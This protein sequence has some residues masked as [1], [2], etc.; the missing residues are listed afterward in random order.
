MKRL[1]NKVI[2]R[3]D[4][5]SYFGDPQVLENLYGSIWDR[6]PIHFAVIPKIYSHQIEAPQ[7]IQHE[8]DF[9][10]IQENT[11]LVSF[12]K[13]KISEGKI[14]ILQHGITHRDYD[15]SY[16]LERLGVD[17]LAEELTE[18]KRILEETFGVLID[19]IVAPHDRFSCDAIRAIE[20]VGYT[21][22]SRGF[23]P[24]PREIQM[25]NASYILAYGRLFF[26]YLFRGRKFRY[27]HIL[28]FGKHKEIF[29]YRIEGK[30]RKSI[31]DIIEN[32][33]ADGVIAMT[34]HHRTFTNVHG[35]VAEYLLDVLEVER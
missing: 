1:K 25:T 15:D 29:N 21:Y 11:Q 2:L 12:L 4:D 3:D 18:G 35:E 9:Y 6:A 33:G 17:I 14:K 28:D 19:T 30:D 13:Q 10:S 16:E 32:T 26:Y 20:K 23:A 7:D 31:Q 27:P 22:I 24:L 8:K 34:F 5:L